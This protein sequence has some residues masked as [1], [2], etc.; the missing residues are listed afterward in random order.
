MGSMI[1]WL[2]FPIPAI[3]SPMLYPLNYALL[4]LALTVPIIIAGYKFYTVGYK[5]IFNRSPNMESLV[6]IGTTAAFAYSLVSVYQISNGNFGAV[7][8]LYFETA[9]VIITLILLGKSL[10]AVSKGRTSEAIKKLMG[11][12]PKLSLIHIS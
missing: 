1:G 2:G 12:A 5:A 9:G 10:E 4:Q 11:L 3:V 7:E 6:A 8:G